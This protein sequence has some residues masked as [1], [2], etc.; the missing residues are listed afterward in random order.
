MMMQR[1][2]ELPADQKELLDRIEGFYQSFN[3]QEWQSCFAFVDPRLKD[4]SGISRDN[5][6]SSLSSF[7][8]EFGPIDDIHVADMKLYSKVPGSLYGDRE[9]AHGLVE[10]RDREQK[11]HEFQE[12]WVKDQGCWYTRMVGLV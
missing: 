12:R 5:Y 2:N 10:W 7:F 11:R 4:E 8:S 6:Q 9:F 3:A 1:I